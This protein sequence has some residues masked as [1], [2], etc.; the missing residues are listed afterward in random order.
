MAPNTTVKLQQLESKLDKLI[1][2]FSAFEKLE[3]RIAEIVEERVEKLLQEKIE[4]IKDNI[5]KDLEKRFKTNSEEHAEQDKRK[6]NL[7]IVNIPESPLKGDEGKKDDNKTVHN[8]LS[9]ISDVQIQEIEEPIRLGKPREDG[10]PRLLKITIKNKEKRVTLLK[11]SKKLNDGVTDDSKKVYIN[12][13]LT[14]EE[15]KAEKEQRDTLRKFRKDFPELD[16][17][18]DR[19]GNLQ[20]KKKTEKTWTAHRD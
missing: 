12:K 9:K 17:R 16:F 14:P 13:D 18:M 3:N 4:E 6:D 5:T 8:L 1:E 10:K 2:K 20:S 15:R 19:E 11:N 7:I